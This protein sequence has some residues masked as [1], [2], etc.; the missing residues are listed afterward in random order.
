MK[1]GLGGA[2]WNGVGCALRATILNVF[3]YTPVAD[4]I[5]DM[6][7]EFYAPVCPGCFLGAVDPYA[8]LEG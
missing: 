4:I 1:P 5:A 6:L 2:R 8:H 3:R 7:C